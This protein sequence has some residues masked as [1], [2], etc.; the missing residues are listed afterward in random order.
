MTNRYVTSG[1]PQG[2]YQPGSNDEVLSNELGIIDLD[3]MDDVELVL[4]QEL[5]SKLLDDI[6]MDQQLT[7]TDL[8]EWHK[9]WL[10]QVYPWAG[11]Y[12]TVNMQK[13]EFM[14][15]AAHL[16]PGLM[17]DFE[18]DF[19]VKHTPCEGF[20]ESRLIESLAIC[21]VELI[22]IHPFREGNG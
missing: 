19:L 11:E 14:F 6:E 20:D 9:I 8:C 7:V 18:R 1:N 16:I 12:R 10:G 2:Q 5:Q 3:E 4:L 15:A 13:G 21:H 22:I 17:L